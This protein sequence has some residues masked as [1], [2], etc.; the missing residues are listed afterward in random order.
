MLRYESLILAHPNI[1][2]DDEL[3]LQEYFKQLATNAK[4]E[5]ISFDKWGKYTLAFPVNKQDYGVYFLIRYEIPS[6]VVVSTLKDLDLFFKIKFNE[7]VM[8][9]VNRRLDANVSLEYQK[10]EP[11][12]S[13]TRNVVYDENKED[14]ADDSDDNER[15]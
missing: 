8:R 12:G 9:Y 2:S 7:V 14:M 4:G 5:F 6:S 11:L 1:T 13:M 10:P 3:K 15:D